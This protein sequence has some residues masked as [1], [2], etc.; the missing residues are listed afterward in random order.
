MTVLIIDDEIGILRYIS[1][2]LRNVGYE[3]VVADGGEEALA[4]CKSQ[5]ID[6]MI[7][8][9][10]HASHER[11]RSRRVYECPFPPRAHHVYIGVSGV[12]RNRGRADRSRL[13]AGVHIS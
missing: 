10:A 3:I 8:D 6:L 5:V 13:R 1:A 4:L 9:V 12:K 11:L 7:S 2:I